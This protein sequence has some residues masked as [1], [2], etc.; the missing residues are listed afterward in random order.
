MPAGTRTT[1]PSPGTG[2]EHPPSYWAA[3]AGLQPPDDGPLSGPA[4]AE[5][6]II[7]GGYTGLSCAYHLAHEHGIRALVLEAN[8]PG[9]GCSGRNGGFARAAIGRYSFGKMIDL[10]G[11][12]CGRPSHAWDVERVSVLLRA[13]S[14]DAPAEAWRAVYWYAA[15]HEGTICDASSGAHAATLRAA[16]GGPYV[17]VSRGTEYSAWRSAASGAVPRC[18]ARSASQPPGPASSGTSARNGA[19]GTGRSASCRMGRASPDSMKG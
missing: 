6:A 9:W 14:V 17:Y 7:G 19:L 18:I 13:E 16:T 5:I 12:D 4:D 11:R 10:W 8:R 2:L 1:A 15:A 3:T